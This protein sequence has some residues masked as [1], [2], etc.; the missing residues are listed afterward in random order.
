MITACANRSGR[1]RKGRS[2]GSAVKRLPAPNECDGQQDLPVPVAMNHDKANGQKHVQYCAKAVKTFWNVKTA[3]FLALWFWFLIAGEYKLFRD[4]GVVW[5]IVVGENILSTAHFPQTD[6]F[7]FTF[8]GQPW[9]ARQWV[10]ECALALLHRMSGFDGVL[11][12]TVTLL[13]CFYT[14]LAH[15]FLRAGV[16]AWLAIILTV[17]TLKA[18]YYYLHP[19]PLL[20]TLVLLGWTFA[21][22]C[23]FE[24]G[25]ISFRGLFWLVPVTL[26]WAN[27]HDGV[28]GGIGTI[29]LAMA[30]WAFSMLLHGDSPIRG[31]RQLMLLGAIVF[32]CGLATL[33]NPYGFEVPRTWMR[34][35]TSPVLPRIIE[36]HLP[37][38]QSRIV[39]AVIL[40]GLLYLAAL[41]GVLPRGRAFT[42]LVPIVWFY[43]AWTHMRHGPLFVTTAAIALANMYP[44][45]SWMVS[46]SG[47]GSAVSC[48]PGNVCGRWEKLNWRPAILPIALVLTTVALQ[49]AA[50]PFPIL[51]RGWAKFDPQ[52]WPVDLLPELRAYE[53]S[54]PPGTPIFN[55]ILLGGFLIYYTP[56]LRVFIDDRC[57]LYGDEQLLAYNRA[58]MED[59]G[60]VEC[61]AQQFGFDR[62]LT[63]PGTP[64]DSYLRRANNWVVVRETRA[65]TLYERRTAKNIMQQA[66]ED[67]LPGKAV[68][69]TAGGTCTFLLLLCPLG[70]YLISSGLIMTVRLMLWLTCGPRSLGGVILDLHTMLLGALCLL[71]GYQT[72][73]LSAYAKIFGWISGLLPQQTLSLRLFDHVNLERGLL[74]GATLLLI[75][76]GLALWLLHK[77]SASSLGPLYVQVTLRPVLWGFTL[78]VLGVQTIYGSFFLSMLGMM[79]PDRE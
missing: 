75:R 19:R 57:E 13:A 54:H 58:E 45:V 60:A 46:L 76:V 42:W 2:A 29:G 61:W 35:L 11:L 38:I 48:L 34:L 49:R 50:V 26:V 44:F 17:L 10:G 39:W 64:I 18:S 33:V 20:V 32:C 65:A 5:H 53:S 7:S 72:L 9:I 51:G 6:G 74:V 14:W 12:G 69:M 63:I 59:P 67:R 23:D 3:I 37:L 73:W 43:L 22:L 55:Q 27:A 52:V 25:R 21:R 40:F 15:R 41:V 16:P 77:W 56:G 78:M 24:A 4:P 66:P 62:A 79:K 68:S 1:S 70:L 47:Q 36:E 28:L 71:L 8:A 30:G 31:F